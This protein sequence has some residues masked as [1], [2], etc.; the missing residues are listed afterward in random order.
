MNEQDA[1]AVA[2][3]R[4]VESADRERALWA[5]ADRSWASRA[6]AEVVG[7]GATRHEFVAR[8]GVLALGR[9]W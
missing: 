9:L 2:A 1:L 3:V 5:D 7:A 8:R 6:A 4:A